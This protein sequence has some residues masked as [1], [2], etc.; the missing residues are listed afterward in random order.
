MHGSNKVLDQSK[1]FN[2]EDILFFSIPDSHTALEGTP[3]SVPVQSLKES[4]STGHSG[5]NTKTLQVKL[6]AK[7]QVFKAPARCLDSIQNA[8]ERIMA[9]PIPL[10]HPQV[11]WEKLETLG[12][13]CGLKMV[14]QGV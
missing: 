9:D 1:S 6:P 5:Y 13:D 2:L 7:N 4:P 14:A 3:L 11:R 8:L 12:I 10:N